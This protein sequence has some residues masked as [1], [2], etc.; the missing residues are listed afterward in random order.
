M[1]KNLHKT[2]ME[3]RHQLHKYRMSLVKKRRLRKE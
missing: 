3:F 1:D 2:L